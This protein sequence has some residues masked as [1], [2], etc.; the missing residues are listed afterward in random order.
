M[1]K[2]SHVEDKTKMYEQSLDY[3]LGAKEEMKE[4]F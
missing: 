2:I 4:G 3:N 1:P